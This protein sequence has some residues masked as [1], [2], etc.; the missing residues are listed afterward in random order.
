MLLGKEEGCRMP[1]VPFQGQ[2]V[3]AT[4]V[5]FQTRREDWN[6]YQL[7][8]GSVIRIKLV[9]GEIL[10][11]DGKYD[12]ERNPIYIVKSKNVLMVRSPDTLKKQP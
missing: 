7:V 2:E 5:D 8:D 9:A 6:E 4:E 12:D 3:D 11:V 1:K 10:R